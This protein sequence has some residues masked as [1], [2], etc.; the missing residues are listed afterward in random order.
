MILGKKAFS[1]YA[2]CASSSFFN[3]KNSAFCTSKPGC[4]GLGHFFADWPH[5]TGNAPFISATG[6][7]KNTPDPSLSRTAVP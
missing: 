3:S 2:S 5:T 6:L 1:A 4:R 7:H